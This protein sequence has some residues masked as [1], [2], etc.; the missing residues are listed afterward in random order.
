M[1]LTFDYLRLHR[2]CWTLLRSAKDACADSLRQTF[3]SDY[4]E[5]ENQLPFIVGY[6]F[7]CAF[8]A[9]KVGKGDGSTTRGKVFLEA[10][11]AIDVMIE[12]GEGAVCAKM[13]E[14]YYN[15]AVDWD[16]FEDDEDSTP[17]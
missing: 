8:T 6:L 17:V 2:S 16:D 11:G 7:M 4:L 10:A 15:Y 12:T 13:M 5:G 9:D 1:H 3:G 14:E